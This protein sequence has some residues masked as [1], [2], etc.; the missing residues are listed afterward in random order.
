MMESVPQRG[1]ASVRSDRK[2]A[3]VL[4]GVA[5]AVM[6]VPSL[7]VT[8]DVAPARIRATALGAFNA[9]GSLGFIAGPLVGGRVSESVAVHTSWLTGYR[10]AFAVA[11]VSELLCVAVALPFLMRLVRAGRTT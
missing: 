2:G 11:G 1:R 9:A 3:G 7:V 10:S 5:S 8:S 6:F 4:L